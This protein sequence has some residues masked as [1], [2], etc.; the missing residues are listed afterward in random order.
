MSGCHASIQGR[1]EKTLKKLK[2]KY[3]L[4]TLWSSR[5]GSGGINF[6]YNNV[7]ELTNNFTETIV[8]DDTY[9][10]GTIEELEFSASYYDSIVDIGDYFVALPVYF[11]VSG[12]SDN[13]GIIRFDKDFTNT[14]F[15]YFDTT[16]YNGFT[17]DFTSVCC[18]EFDGA[19]FISD[20]NANTAVLHHINVIDE[21]INHITLDD[22]DTTSGYYY[23][24]FHVNNHLFIMGTENTLVY[25]YENGTFSFVNNPTLTERDPSYNDNAINYGYHPFFNVKFTKNTIYISDFVGGYIS[26]NNDPVT[27]R[28]RAIDKNNFTLRWENSNVGTYDQGGSHPSTNGKYIEEFS[29]VLS[30]GNIVSSQIHGRNSLGNGSMDAFTDVIE[31]NEFDGGIMFTWT[32]DR[33]VAPGAAAIHQTDSKDRIYLTEFEG[34]AVLNT[35]TGKFKRIFTPD[36]ISD[37]QENL[38]VYESPYLTKN[39]LLL[40]INYDNGIY[41][42]DTTLN[43]PKIEELNIS[44]SIDTV[45]TLLSMTTESLIFFSGGFSNE[46]IIQLTFN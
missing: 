40:Q 21:T 19:V 7:L 29:G 30:N 31:F 2:E 28:I 16:Q 42:T 35:K 34:Y 36:Y 44:N 13:L 22:V 27:K 45:A 18:K 8:F 33:G 12:N 6:L 17:E 5:M 15:S 14:Y 41:V 39:G 24:M 1:F 11:T 20:D 3:G 4:T 46:N 38:D 25:K 9:T 32:S 10:D 23:T 43:N 26:N 37:G